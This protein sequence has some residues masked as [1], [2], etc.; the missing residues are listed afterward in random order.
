MFIYNVWWWNW[1]LELRTNISL[2]LII[3]K[4]YIICFAHEE[5]KRHHKRSIVILE[6][7]LDDD[8]TDS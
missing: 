3:I 4:Q 2:L 6:K 5:D 8:F 7:Y 1:L